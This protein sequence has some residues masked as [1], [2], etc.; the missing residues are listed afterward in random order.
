MNALVVVHLIVGLSS[1]ISQPV[2]ANPEVRSRV[3]V[4]A[5]CD[6]PKNTV[7]NEKQVAEKSIQDGKLPTDLVDCMKNAAGYETQ[8]A[9]VNG[10]LV[11]YRDLKPCKTKFRLMNPTHEGCVRRKF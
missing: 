7:I 10:Q 6:I 1:A 4:Y 11:S 3:I 8:Y 2:A 9:L 5:L